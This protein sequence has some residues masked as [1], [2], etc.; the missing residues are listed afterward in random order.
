MYKINSY[1]YHAH[2]L[3]TSGGARKSY[4]KKPKIFLNMSESEFKE[5]LSP[6]V[7]VRDSGIQGKGKMR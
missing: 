3:I 1:T 7:E 6:K 5:G 2:F 4:L